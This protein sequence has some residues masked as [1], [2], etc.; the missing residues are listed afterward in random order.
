MLEKIYLNG[1][2]LDS[3]SNYFQSL[4]EMKNSEGNFLPGTFQY[5]LLFFQRL[6]IKLKAEV[7]PN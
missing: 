1:K 7:K 6:C 2:F 3:L 5:E 4:L